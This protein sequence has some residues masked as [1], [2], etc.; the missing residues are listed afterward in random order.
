MAT[1]QRQF[2]LGLI[3]EGDAKGG[4]R[5]TAATEDQLKKLSAQHDRT[6]KSNEKHRREAER[7]DKRMSQMAATVGRT[8]AGL[9]GLA[10]AG[11]AVAKVSGEMLTF[12][13]T[14]SRIEGL[15]GVA[16]EQVDAMGGSLLDLSPATGKGPNELAEALFFVT[17]A[18]YRGA[19]ALQIV[20][21]S[22]RASTAGLG[23][24]AAIAD[25]VTSAVNAY[26]PAALSAAES[27]DILVAA[28]REGKLEAAEMG[29]ALADVVGTAAA[30]DIAFADVAG[31][32]AVFS[33]TG[34]SAGKGAT[35]VNAILNA[36]LKTSAEGERALDGVGL[37]L[38]QLREIASEDGLV[39]VMRTLD[40]AFAGNVGQL[41]AVITE[42][43]AF[44]G[45]MNALAQ[46]S[47]TVDSVLRGVT[48][49][50]GALDGA[51]EAAARTGDFELN[52]A[53]QKLNTSGMAFAEEVLPPMISGLAEFLDL[54][55]EGLTN[56]GEGLAA[57]AARATGH[58]VP[59]DELERLVRLRDEARELGNTLNATVRS[60]QIGDLLDR[61]PWLREGV[62]DPAIAGL[63]DIRMLLGDTADEAGNLVE[64]TGQGSDV[65]IPFARGLEDAATGAGALRE[66]S[67]QASEEV[68]ELITQQRTLLGLLNQGLSVT[69]AETR[70][71][72]QEQG[73]TDAQIEQ[74]L[75]LQARIEGIKD[76]RAEST[77]TTDA[78]AK[79]EERLHLRIA[80]EARV[81]EL[82]QMGWTEQQAQRH[83]ELAFA[84]DL[85]RAYLRLKNAREDYAD[86]QDATPMKDLQRELDSLSFGNQFAQ[87]F[88][89]ASRAAG[90]LLDGLNG[91]IDAQSTFADLREKHAGDEEALAAIQQ[92]SQQATVGL[93]GDMTQ[94]AKGFFSEGSAGYEAL[95][96]AEQ[97]FRAIELAMAAKN[98]AQK[99]GFLQTETA[100]TV[101]SAATKA[102]A[103][104]AAAQTSSMVGLPFPANLAALAATTAAIAAL[105]V[106]LQGGS[107]A[108]AG[109]LDTGSTSG[110]RTRGTVLGDPEAESASIANAL[111]GLADIASE[112]L[113]YTSQM[114]RSLQNIESAL[115]GVTS[116]FARFAGE[117]GV[118]SLDLGGSVGSVSAEATGFQGSFY[119]NIVAGL[120]GND[121]L[122]EDERAAFERQAAEA[123]ADI[124][125][126]V[127]S[128]LDNLGAGIGSAVGALGGDVDDAL[129]AFTDIQLPDLRIAEQEDLDA[130]LE[131]FFSSIGDS[132][133]EIVSQ[134]T[135]LAIGDFQR[136]GEGALETLTRVASGVEYARDVA[137][138][139][140]V[141]LA[142]LAD[143]DRRAEDLGAELVRLSVAQANAGTGLGELVAQYTG[144]A[145]DTADFARELIDLRDAM[146][147]MGDQA[148]DVTREMLDAAGGL[149]R[150]ADG[151][152]TYRE[153]FFS[154]E[155]QLG[156][157]R[158]ELGEELADLGLS[159]PSTRDALRDLIESVR[160]NDSL[161][162]A[163]I[164]LVPQF[165][166]LYSVQRD[167]A[168]S[169]AD[170]A[171]QQRRLAESIGSASQSIAR[172]IAELRGQSVAALQIDN[173]LGAVNSAGSFAD[174]V[175]QFGSIQQALTA[176]LNEQLDAINAQSAATDAQDQQQL[177]ALNAQISAVNEQIRAA[178]RLRD[179]AQGIRDYVSGLD[180][181][182][183]AAGT[184]LQQLEAAQA[185]F[186]TMT[187]AAR[188]GDV[189][190]AGNLQGRAGDV[191]RLAQDIYGSSGQFQQI[192]QSIVDSLGATA[193]QVDVTTPELQ[194]MNNQLAALEQQQATL[195][196]IRDNQPQQV[197]DLNS[198]AADQATALEEGLADRLQ[199]VQG[200][201]GLIGDINVLSRDQ[202]I[203]AMGVLQDALA[204][205]IRGGD[206]DTVAGLEQLRA[207]IESGIASITDGDQLISTVLEGGFDSIAGALQ[208]ALVDLGSDVSGL[209][210]E[211]TRALLGNADEVAE[212]I[213]QANAQS[214][215][216]AELQ[217]AAMLAPL[218]ALGKNTDQMRAE[219][220]AQLHDQ[221]L[222]QQLT[223]SLTDI[224]GAETR[225]VQDL[226][227]AAS[228]II[229]GNVAA[230]GQSV[231]RELLGLNQLE[232]LTRDDIIASLT[233]MANLESGSQSILD[234]LLGT[235]RNTE[236][237][238]GQ[239]AYGV[240]QFDAQLLKA[241]NTI[242]QN[243]HHTNA[244]IGNV[245]AGINGLG[246]L[247]QDTRGVIDHLSAIRGWTF[248]SRQALNAQNAA[249]GLPQF[250]HGGI[251]TGPASGY[252]V[253]MHRTEAIMPAVRM[254]D[255]NFGVRVDQGNAELVRELRAL[256]DRV[257]RQEAHLQAL[258]RVEQSGWKQSLELGQKQLRDSN[259]VA[260]AARLEA[261]S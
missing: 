59:E 168:Q 60:Q 51:F 195:E 9:V 189:D 136:F 40:D 10:S 3:I 41:R 14:L 26:G 142:S 67:E 214:I 233:G 229:S 38:E 130:A 124:T 204:T 62:W 116:V 152:E 221:I 119:A 212:A 186:A 114:L 196:Q 181:G 85:E 193:D 247:L 188:A 94:A 242:N 21:A 159:L 107:G 191:L 15:V 240:G 79:A 151:F 241:A 110:L 90:D 37:S 179:V 218:N 96:A 81:L 215:A 216:D 2:K 147:Y 93:F 248:A 154:A 228:N 166:E 230:S 117:T 42:T 56:A 113:A 49:S 245:I 258:V 86:Q 54:T 160:G 164:A 63:A 45:V 172:Q 252:R 61:F 200:I 259:A 84:S 5:A 22:A 20:E 78:A 103:E 24:T 177:D 129:A 55:T 17:S 243:I 223:A 199:D 208:D 47:G 66:G 6:R 198:A 134:Q 256:R 145:E 99:L 89:D 52:Q 111:D 27:T 19:E 137:D 250:A 225:G 75:R 171:E 226:V 87:G 178:E 192:R 162:G 144:S 58:I 71:R 261:A 76:A 118:Q 72:L 131:A 65:V 8:A 33:R 157:L 146:R 132:A 135:N 92:K 133:V 175:S 43:E 170:A 217:T 16:R 235:N 203:D 173:V 91:L 253:E 138:E 30:L 194:A 64:I 77:K 185:R 206:L 127:Q 48:E 158:R 222:Q 232:S 74:Y 219:M 149:D 251:A 161:Y 236:D 105:G 180:V 227:A 156:F 167:V 211:L 121:D 174:L 39:A 202:Q 106:S 95:T 239:T 25:T 13:R 205:V 80:E 220:V 246:G 187:A 46:D 101:T 141:S 57:M 7:M 125:Q 254:S 32:M 190:A 249:D 210:A 224:L 201:L 97:T 44:R 176:Q 123:S 128:I 12:E 234:A 50:T 182:Q 139:L 163:L 108:A 169:S 231:V 28:V 23:E 140:D 104:G 36:L 34:T 4:I 29:P 1:Q 53:L 11:A 82:M 18:G 237:N 83:A 155:E 148:A 143:V 213:Q 88:D 238:T 122:L 68:A 209:S 98:L 183:F 184:P 69:E 255:G 115:A 197:T 73:A 257:E 70:A 260:R 120:I 165:D 31:T 102:S 153:E 150:F 126:G 244:G 207:Q 100:A 112:E 35:A 109:A